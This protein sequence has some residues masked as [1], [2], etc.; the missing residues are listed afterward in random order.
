MYKCNRAGSISR[1]RNLGS[2]KEEKESIGRCQ[3]PDRQTDIEE[4]G[5]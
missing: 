5:N 4:E 1:R 3:G 2:R